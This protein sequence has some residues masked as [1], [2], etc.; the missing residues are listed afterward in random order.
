M[1]NTAM[2]DENV[3]AAIQN[4]MQRIDPQQKTGR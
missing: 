3:I 4:A 1:L 2:G